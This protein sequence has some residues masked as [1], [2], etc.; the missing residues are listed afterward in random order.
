MET[1]E[2]LKE[3]AVLEKPC[4]CPEPTQPISDEDEAKWLDDSNCPGPQVLFPMLREKC[5]HRAHRHVG[6]APCRIE[7]CAEH[8]A[9]CPGWREKTLDEARLCLEEL[10]VAEKEMHGGMAL[11]VHRQNGNWVARYNEIDSIST[12][13][14]P[15][16]AVLAA[17]H[18]ASKVKENA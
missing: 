9:I 1:E 2:I 18:E 7:N 6:T 16:E 3:L 5:D 11:A 12:A 10:L 13:D 15:T 17:L 4:G 8:R 14:T